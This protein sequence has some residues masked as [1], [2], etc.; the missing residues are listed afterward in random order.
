MVQMGAAVAMITIAT[1]LAI[2]NSLHSNQL[3]DLGRQ[4]KAS[5]NRPQSLL[6][7]PTAAN[8]ISRYRED[9]AICG[10]QKAH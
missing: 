4:M 7:F 1:C 6:N 10:N 5:R 3:S 8:G 2:V 9:S